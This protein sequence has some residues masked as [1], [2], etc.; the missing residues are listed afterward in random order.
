MVKKKIHKT[1]VLEFKKGQEIHLDERLYP[2][3][4]FD[5]CFD[6][7]DDDDFEDAEICNRSVKLTMVT[8]EDD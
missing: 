7:K 2:L 6:K 1:E 4:M 8:Y 5:R 3:A